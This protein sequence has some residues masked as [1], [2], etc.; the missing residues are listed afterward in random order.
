VNVISCTGPGFESESDGY[1]ESG[2][3]SESDSDSRLPNGEAGGGGVL[4][5]ASCGRS[6][7]ESEVPGY[8]GEF[9][10]APPE[11]QRIGQVRR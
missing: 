10:D 11:A 7:K 2:S 6:S 9:D 8:G 5:G 3:G 4:E 1:G